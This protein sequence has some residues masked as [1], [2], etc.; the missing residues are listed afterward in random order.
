MQTAHIHIKDLRL[1][2][3][4]GINPEEITKKQDVLVN[5]HMEFPLSPKID[6]DTID[7]TVNYRSIV[8]RIIPFVEDNRFGLLE[9]LTQDIL[10]MVM[11]TPG[12]T[13]A[14]VEVDKPHA[15]RFAES[16]SCSL[17]SGQK[18]P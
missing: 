2:T 15:L 8:K 3:F 17:K 12:I 9:R 1:R 5:I 10:E 6:L 16:V 7:Q 4:I 13:Y 11:Q 18:S 14:H